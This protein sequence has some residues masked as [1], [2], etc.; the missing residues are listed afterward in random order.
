MLHTTS[1]KYLQI[2]TKD[3]APYHPIYSKIFNR[4]VSDKNF[5]IYIT[6]EGIKALNEVN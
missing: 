2:R 5:A 6:K 3:S 4:Y 1:G